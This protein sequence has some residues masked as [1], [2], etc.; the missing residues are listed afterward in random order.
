MK[1]KII[2]VDFKNKK[3]EDKMI[4]KSINDKK[5]KDAM[6]KVI[7]MSKKIDW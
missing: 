3:I 6:K 1:N 4:E 5:K 2:K 7:K